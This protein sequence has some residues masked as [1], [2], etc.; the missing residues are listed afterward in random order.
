MEGMGALEYTVCRGCNEFALVAGR[1]GAGRV[2]GVLFAMKR[3]LG[4][5]IVRDG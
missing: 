2:R 1:T 4:L 5:L 3:S